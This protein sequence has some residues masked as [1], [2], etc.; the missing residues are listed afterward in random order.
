M[1]LHFISLHVYRHLLS[2]I[3][4]IEIEKEHIN[5]FDGLSM[6]WEEIG[7]KEKTSFSKTYYIIT[8]I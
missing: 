1:D 7:M 5:V 4:V 8:P 6:F 3:S 2:Q